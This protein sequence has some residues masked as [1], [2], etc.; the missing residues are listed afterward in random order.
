MFSSFTTRFT[1]IKNMKA[2][3][4]G[5]FFAAVLLTGCTHSPSSHQKDKKKT[6]QLPSSSRLENFNRAMFDFNYQILDPYIVRPV[7]V[8]WQSYVPQPA[9]NGLS[10]VLS[11]LE[12]PAS[13]VNSFLVAN[14]Y[15]AMKHFSRFFLNTLLGMGGLID[16]ASMAN[17]TLAKELPH[18]FGSVLG[19]YHVS[20]GPYLTLPGYGSFTLREDAGKWI[21]TTYPPLSYL[22]LWMSTAKWILQGI[23]TRARLLDSDGLLRNSSDPY[24]VVRKAYFQRYDFLAQGGVLKAEINP[25]AKTIEDDLKNI[26]SP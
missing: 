23:E 19:H 9:R 6:D 16:I 21:D 1:E 22:T 4:I 14:P 24:S 2:R 7:A 3:L 25:N 20:Y 12:E 17:P 10:N 13:M 15:E 8:F 5:C 11:N 18:G 26:D